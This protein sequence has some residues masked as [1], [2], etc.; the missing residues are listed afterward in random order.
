M[1]IILIMEAAQI[2]YEIVNFKR[3]RHKTRV[4]E[5]APDFS[6]NQANVDL[7]QYIPG[8]VPSILAFCIFGTTAPFRHEYAQFFRKYVLRYCCGAAIGKKHGRRSRPRKDPVPWLMLQSRPHAHA[9]CVSF[10]EDSDALKVWREQDRDDPEAA[11]KI[12]VKTEILTSITTAGSDADLDSPDAITPTAPN[13][14]QHISSRRTSFGGTSIAAPV[15][16]EPTEPCVAL[17]S[18]HLKGRPIVADLGRDGEG[19]GLGGQ[20]VETWAWL[21]L[22]REPSIASMRSSERPSWSAPGTPVVSRR[23]ALGEVA[24]EVV[25]PERVLVSPRGRGAYS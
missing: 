22:S 20:G 10:P 18:P 19:R 1:A 25:A 14:H 12:N 15:P 5:T 17:S 23:M 6:V 21:S 16:F 7:L 9:E 24:G 13:Q 4:S 3:N 11:A 8:Q 2:I